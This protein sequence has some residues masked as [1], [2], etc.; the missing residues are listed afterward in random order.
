MSESLR[1]ALVREEYSFKI[2][3]GEVR[4]VKVQEDIVD[5]YYSEADAYH[6]IR[7][8]NKFDDDYKEYKVVKIKK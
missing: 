5:V 3:E 7:T 2:V 6:D 1:W 4:R 8:D